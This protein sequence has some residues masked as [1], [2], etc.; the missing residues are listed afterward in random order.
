MFQPEICGNIVDDKISNGNITEI[1]EF[2][3]MAIIQYRTGDGI[4]QL[5]GGS[6]ISKRYILTAAHCIARLQGGYTV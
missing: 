6:V 5:C 3:W 2:T 1:L 4:E